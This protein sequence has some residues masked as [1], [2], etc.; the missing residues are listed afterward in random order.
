MQTN[1][2]CA[3]VVRNLINVAEG[4]GFLIN[5]N[6]NYWLPTENGGKYEKTT[7]QN[8]VIIVGAN[9]SGKSKLGAWMEQQNPEKV[10]RVG[11]QRKLNFKE[12]FALKSYSEAEKIVLFGHTNGNAGS[13]SI[14]KWK[15]NQYTTKLI[16][17]YE[18][19]LAALLALKN[20]EQDVFIKQFEKAKATNSLSG[21]QK[22]E[23]VVD[24]LVSIWKEVLPQRDLTVEDSKFLASIKSSGQYSATQMSDGERAV[25]YLAAQVLCVP[26]NKTLIIDEPELHLHC[27][28]MNRLWKTLESYRSDCLFIYIT[29][30]L[31]FAAGHGNIDKIWIKEYDGRNW[32]YDIIQD[33]DVPEDLLLEILGSRRNVL[34]VEGD[35]SSY[36]TQLYSLLYPKYLIIPC[37]SCTQ[38]IQRT[39]AFKASQNLHDCKVYGLIDRD[40]RSE[41]EIYSYKADNIYVLEV[42]EVENLFLVEELIRFMAH[43]FGENEEDIF[44][45][46]KQF[47][48]NT[49]FRNMI[50]Q[51]ICQSVV[52][53]IKYQLACITITKDDEAGVKKSLQEGIDA[54]DFETIKKAK[55]AVFQKALADNDYKTVLKVFNEKGL[56]SSVGQLMGINK[57]DYLKKV[58]SLLRGD[59][60]NQ[61]QNAI[62]PYLPVEIPK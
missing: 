25:L 12:D 20:N 50:N 8:S 28:I 54:I 38:V 6:Y 58:I 7:I 11:A 23:T 33:E 29:H 19:V 48:I 40:Y 4:K 13:K 18:D 34:F 47:V 37:G 15:T 27:S 2:V 31:K 39:K 30:D 14:Y 51:Q 3:E 60:R 21:L 36:D 57:K 5:M 61:I 59:C 44:T 41:H 22:P 45:K 1:H 16:E 56:V 46:V 55:E 62:N 10:H 32:K 35:K 42:A 26:A 43:Q 17:D 24:K 9:G 52:A 53:E 49:K